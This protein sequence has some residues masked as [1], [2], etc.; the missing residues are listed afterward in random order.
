M[1]THA[2]VTQE[3]TIPMQKITPC[4]WF[5]GNAEEAVA[6]MT[7]AMLPMKKLDIATLVAA[8]EGREMS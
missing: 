8:A 1:N 4:L 5:P 7:T 2:P 3:R 6:R